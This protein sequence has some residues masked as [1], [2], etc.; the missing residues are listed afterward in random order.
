MDPHEKLE[1][2]IMDYV[3]SDRCKSHENA[4][5]IWKRNPWELV[6]LY[7]AIAHP[8]MLEFPI[9]FPD[10]QYTLEIEK[11]MMNRDVDRALGNPYVI[12][13]AERAQPGEYELDDG[14]LAIINRFGRITNPEDI[15]G[16]E[17]I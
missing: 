6:S 8:E 1:L 9:A 10:H 4:I 16:E 13:L 17:E 15:W 7:E 2:E 3:F 12:E 5:A 14:E 11:D